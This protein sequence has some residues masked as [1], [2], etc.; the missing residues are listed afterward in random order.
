MKPYKDIQRPIIQGKKL[1]G[2]LGSSYRDYLAS[3]VLFNN[4]Q[5]VIACCLANTSIEKNFK[6]LLDFEEKKISFTHD[7]TKLLPDIKEYDLELYN[8]LNVNFLNVL[9]KI[10]SSR[11]LGD[12]DTGYNMVIT[13]NKYLAELDYIYSILEPKLRILKS[14]TKEVQSTRY[15]VDIVKQNPALLTNNYILL[16]LDKTK[17]IEQTDFVF[18]LRMHN[19]TVLE[20]SYST[21]ESKNDGLFDFDSLKPQGKDNKSFKLCYKA[22]EVK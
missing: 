2:F 13:K 9:T 22:I 20:V 4:K 12:C 19:H 7:L 18:E 10:Y 5:L 14:G 8:K 11:Y 16:N 6:A 15:E 3:R 21:N 1:L 17:F